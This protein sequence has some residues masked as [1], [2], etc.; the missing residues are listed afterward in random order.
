MKIAAHGSVASDLDALFRLGTVSGLREGQ[1]L[2]RFL[3]RGDE[4][5]FAAIVSRYGPM[6][7]GVCRA[8]RLDYQ[9]VDDAFQATFLVLARR[10]RDIRD[11]ER[12]GPWL[13]G[14]AHR[15]ASKARVASA[16]RRSKEVLVAIEELRFHPERRSADLTWDEQTPVVHEELARLPARYRDPAILCWVDGQTHLEAAQ[17]MGC[18][19]GTVK[20]RLSRARRLLRDRLT[21]RGVALSSVACASVLANGARGQISASVVQSLSQGAVAFARGGA[22]SACLIVPARIAE[23]VLHA[24]M[25]STIKV[26]TMLVAL[27]VATAT[28][29][30]YAGSR[31]NMLTGLTQ[32]QE[33]SERITDRIPRAASSVDDDNKHAPDDPEPSDDDDSDEVARQDEEQE[34]AGDLA[35]A[36][37]NAAR[38]TFDAA[39]AN[40]EA[41]SIPLDRLVSASERLLEAEIET[42]DQP[43]ARKAALRRHL[44]LA[45]QLRDREFAGFENRTRKS[46]D[47][48][49]SNLALSEAANRAEREI[50]PDDLDEPANNEEADQP[51]D[52][53]VPDEPDALR[54]EPKAD[55]DAL[56]EEA[57]RVDGQELTRRVRERLEHAITLP[58]SEETPLSDVVKYIQSAT[59]CPELPGG[60]QVYLDPLGLLEKELT[61]E[62]PITIEL[63]GISLKRGLFLALRSVG[64]A[65]TIQDGLLI[66][67][68]T[69]KLEELLSTPL[70]VGE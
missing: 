15:V 22:V 27:S 48:A 17:R 3:A 2:E 18:P 43:S 54:E 24:M 29:G 68:T 55:E 46:V 5:A 8:M 70:I 9:A 1:L 14:V 42:A 65:Y 51:R 32:S 26:F 47:L 11:P 37:L 60:I 41:G 53:D 57:T 66:I 30:V 23:R 7:R 58:F 33:G 63:Q 13:Y 50:K 39:K 56:T 19:V 36:G 4:T 35:K 31:G 34:P 25:I 21:R 38:E 52:A 59:D 20:G 16:R 6:V 44:K 40:Y 45:G 61:R 10:A 62:S 67:S 28:A 49:E 69:E 64:L 12:L